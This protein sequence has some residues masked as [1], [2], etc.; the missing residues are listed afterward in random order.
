LFLVHVPSQ[1]ITHRRGKLIAIGFQGKVPRV[2]QMELQRLPVAIAWLG[3]SRRVDLVV[4]PPRD[5]TR[6]LVLAKVLLPA[7]IERRVA[8]VAQEQIELDLIAPFAIEQE[9]IFRRT[10]RA[11]ELR[12]LHSVRVL[13][14]R[15]FVRHQIANASRSSLLLIASSYRSPRLRA[16]R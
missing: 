16:Q 8:A 9:L 1:E 5:Q 10:V 11:D 7:R 13:P 6:R 14:L 15:G 3:S 4:L 12:V 2:H